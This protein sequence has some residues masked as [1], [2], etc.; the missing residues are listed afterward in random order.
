M[1]APAHQTKRIEEFRLSPE[2]MEL[3]ALLDL[4]GQL[5]DHAPRAAAQL[6]TWQAAA[7]LLLE[8][9]GVAASAIEELTVDLRQRWLEIAHET[10]HSHFRSPLGEDATRLPSGRAV[11][12]GYERELDPA[13]L[14]ARAERFIPACPGRDARHLVFSSGQSALAAVLMAAGAN[15]QGRALRVAH[16]GSYF[17]TTELLRLTGAQSWQD[18]E[19]EGAG[20]EA[21]VAIIEPVYL[22]DAFHC[23]DLSRLKRRLTASAPRLVLVDATISHLRF[24]VAELAAAL[25]AGTVLVRMSSL[26][27]LDQAGLELA[28]AG[29]L[30]VFT[31]GEDAL[32]DT[33]ARIRATTGTGLAFADLCALDVPF[34]FH[35]GYAARY[36]AAVFAHNARLAQVVRPGPIFRSV[37]HPAL[38]CRPADWAVAPYVAFHVSDDDPAACRALAKRLAGEAA[39][40]ALPFRQ[41]GSF[42]FRTHRFDIVEPGAAPPFLRVAMGAAG[43]GVAETIALLADIEP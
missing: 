9:T 10:A 32:A 43:P 8:Q 5:V 31:A 13:R 23:I 40:R 21:D 42:G 34:V 29:L 30:S 19:G 4:A 16:L 41:G 37:S 27:K 26:L 1:R 35:A 14:E 39:R 36:S 25:P 22:D 33:L 12:F 20:G 3:R 6:R 18:R 38:T 24:P 2:A 28:N 11:D 7:E 17:E 15:V